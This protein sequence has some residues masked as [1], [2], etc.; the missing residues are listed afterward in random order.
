M[1]SVWSLNK[2]MKTIAGALALVSTSAFG[3][4]V[5]FSTYPLMVEQKMVGA[6][7]TG[8]SSD[9]GG[10]GVQARYTQRM[11]QSITLD[12]GAGISGGD[13]SNR[14]FAGVDYEMFPDYMNQPR[15]S[16]KTT[17]TNAEEFDSRRNIIG[18]A[19]TV[20]KGFSFWGK[21]GYPFVSLPVSL[22]LDSDTKQY[23]TMIG[24]NFGILGN[25]PIEGYRDIIGKVEGMVDIKDSYT[26]IFLGLSFPIN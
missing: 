4:G 20:S 6:E 24:A 1:K 22:N 10:V 9:K 13:R 21:E 5:G 18:V 23:E 14:I 15:I 7:M 17:W 12:A 2:S 8:I 26:G 11:T 16:L 3:Y 25:L 19:P